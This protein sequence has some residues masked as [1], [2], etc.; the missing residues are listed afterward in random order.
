MSF[1]VALILI[2]KLFLNRTNVLRSLIFN[3]EQRHIGF[4]SDNST[5]KGTQENNYKQLLMMEIK[6][7]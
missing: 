2:Y 1:R 7:T 6:Y 3:S 4:T 5:L